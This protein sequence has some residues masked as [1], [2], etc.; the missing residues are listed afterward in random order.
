M[1]CLTALMNVDMFSVEG[2]LECLPFV[3]NLG[4]NLPYTDMSES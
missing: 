4:S 1:A 3:R 2:A